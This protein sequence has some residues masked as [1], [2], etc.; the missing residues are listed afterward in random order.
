MTSLTTLFKLSWK[1]YKLLIHTLFIMIKVR[2]MLWFMPFSHIQKSFSNLI[3]SGDRD[4]TVCRLNWSLKVVSHYMPGTTCLTNALAGYSLLSKHGY[5]SIVK[6]GVG[7]SEEG[8]F[9]AHAWLE[10]GDGVV[11]G[12]SEKEYVPLLDFKIK[13]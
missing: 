8:E 5:S 12:E 10:Y 11:I 9:E 2:L 13:S 4:I 3:P 1:D 7:K 6:I